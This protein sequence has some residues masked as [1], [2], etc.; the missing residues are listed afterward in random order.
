MGVIER[1]AYTLYC[2]VLYI[3][4]EQG[5]VGKHRKLMPTGGERIIWGFGDGSTLPVFKT[6]AGTVGAV[7]CWENYMPMMRSAM[8]GKGSMYTA[9]PPL[10]TVIRGWPA[11]SISLL[12]DV[13][14]C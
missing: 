4:P 12:K 14:M 8:Y 7:I 1:T 6:G 9:R 13:A 5:L 3:D 2:T 10:M 11:C